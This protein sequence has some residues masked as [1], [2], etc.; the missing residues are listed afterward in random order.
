MSK[1][2]LFAR[3]L[4]VA[5]SLCTLVGVCMMS[6]FL[7]NFGDED[8]IELKITVNESKKIEFDQIMLIPGESFE[9]KVVLRSDLSGDYDLS[10]DFTE[11]EEGLLKNFIYIKVTVN[12]ETICD[13]LLSELIK[14]DGRV[15]SVYLSR[16]TN[17][18]VVITC[19]MPEETG[20]EAEG[21]F[22]DFALNI[23]SVS[24]E[25]N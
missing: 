20:N 24:K 22:A 18:D 12:G 14:E 10:F 8:D 16:S 17:C 21:T 11:D 25:D 13:K 1:A 5:V 6:Y 15:I 19:Y 9:R 7:V 4:L 2:K 3:I 23:T